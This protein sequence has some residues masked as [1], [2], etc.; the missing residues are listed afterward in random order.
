MVLGITN[1]FIHLPNEIH[2][3]RMQTHEHSY[4]IFIDFPAERK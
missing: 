4:E 3:S 1:L 2:I